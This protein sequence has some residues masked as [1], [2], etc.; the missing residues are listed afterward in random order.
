MGRL[1]GR[2]A[3]RHAGAEAGACSADA[4]GRAQTRHVGG[5]TL[6]S[7]AQL[8]ALGRGG[9]GQALRDSDGHDG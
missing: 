2:G 5:S 7:G 9:V 4:A 8:Y 1:T 6:R 3:A